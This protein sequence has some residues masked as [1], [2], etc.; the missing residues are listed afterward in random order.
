MTQ[1]DITPDY[2]LLCPAKTLL[3]LLI[4]VILQLWQLNFIVPSANVGSGVFWQFHRQD[5][6][7]LFK[8]IYNFEIRQDYK[9]LI[10]NL[11]SPLLN[12]AISAHMLVFVLFFSFIQFYS[13][14]ML[15]IQTTRHTYI[16][17]YC[18]CRLLC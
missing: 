16:T 18:R 3:K 10:L 15:Q 7:F 14:N 6:D 11:D 17:M 13:V 1:S 8:L 4:T 12:Q 9:M 2:S 5:I